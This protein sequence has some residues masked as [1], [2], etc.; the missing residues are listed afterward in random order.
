MSPLRERAY[1]EIDTLTEEQ[2]GYVLNMIV[3]LKEL[4]ARHED[5]KI[6]LAARKAFASMRKHAQE[7][8]DMTLDE[9]N[10]EI[11]AARQERLDEKNIEKRQR[12]IEKLS[13]L[14]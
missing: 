4:E 3:G 11:H 10:D 13:K 14:S 1:A 5:K 12:V 2:L 7:L 8:P 9:I 6:G